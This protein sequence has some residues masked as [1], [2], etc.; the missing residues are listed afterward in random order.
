MSFNFKVCSHY[1]NNLSVLI[2]LA[3]HYGFPSVSASLIVDSNVCYEHCRLRHEIGSAPKLQ[4]LL[5]AASP[6]SI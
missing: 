2:F 5:Q 3:F 6:T 1:R 4:I